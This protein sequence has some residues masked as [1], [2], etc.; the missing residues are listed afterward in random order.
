MHET[1]TLSI[2]AGCI[3][4]DSKAGL[5]D[6]WPVSQVLLALGSRRSSVYGIPTANHKS[7]YQKVSVIRA[8]RRAVHSEGCV[9]Q[10]CDDFL[11]PNW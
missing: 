6:R 7:D 5:D 3:L 9:K 10:T 2:A 11:I 4:R 1:R 8:Q